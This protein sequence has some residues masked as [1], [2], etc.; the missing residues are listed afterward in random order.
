MPVLQF[1]NGK[2]VG[3]E[4]R[5]RLTRPGLEVL[6]LVPKLLLGRGGGRRS[7]RR[8]VRARQA[9]QRRSHLGCVH[10]CRHS[11][12]V[13][14][15]VQHRGPLLGLPLV[16]RRIKG[17]HVQDAAPHSKGEPGGP[18]SRGNSGALDCRRAR[19]HG[20]QCLQE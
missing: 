14:T 1:G 17:V 15:P 6:N 12:I 18:P 13:R 5:A 11:T 16:A 4:Q 9:W 3:G 20:L 19:G 10:A 8:R 7:S 2:L